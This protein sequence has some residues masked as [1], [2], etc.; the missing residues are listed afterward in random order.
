MPVLPTW[1]ERDYQTVALNQ[2]AALAA[3]GHQRATCVLPCG[4]GKTFVAARN[5]LGARRLL[6][7]TPTVALLTQTLTELAQHRPHDHQLAICAANPDPDSVD[8]THPDNITTTVTTNPDQIATF[9]RQHPGPVTVAC[10]YAS[11]QAAI[12]ATHQTGTVWDAIIL[13]EA[14]RTAGLAGKPWA[15]ILDNTQLPARWR[16]ALTATP[17]QITTNP[18]LTDDNGEPLPVA[19]MTDEALYGPIIEPIS[20]RDAITNGH[21]SDY[22][23]AIVGVPRTQLPTLD[24]RAV[25]PTGEIVNADTIA[26]QIALLR[27]AATH[28]HI[29]SVLAFHN[30]VTAS[31]TWAADWQAIADTPT[32]TSPPT[33][34]CTHIDGT[35]P[36]PDRATALN[37]LRNVPDNT[38]RVVTNCKVLSEGIDVPALDA[39]VFAQPRTSAPDIVQIVGRCLRPHPTRA[40]KATIVIPILIDDT[41]RSIETA[42]AHSS[43]TAVW[44]VLTALA[45]ED[46]ALYNTLAHQRATTTDPNTPPPDITVDIEFDLPEPLP[47]TLTE[48][49]RLRVLNRTTSG[50]AVYAA[51]MRTHTLQGH[52]TH[53]RHTYTT[54][55]GYPLGRRTHELRRLHHTGKLH[56]AITHHIE[57]TIPGW[58][59]DTRP[60]TPRRTWDDMATI[61]RRYLTTTGA[62]TIPPH[63]ITRDTNG[64]PVKL[65]HWYHH[66]LTHQHHLTPT[67]QALLDG[68]TNPATAGINPG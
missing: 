54:P 23:I 13:D 27:H 10:T 57:T 62:T 20:L 58:T 52:N 60:A 22:R 25:L 6:I 44:Q 67:Q 26:A 34:S 28:P 38:L 66:Q 43:F 2:L 18:T 35:M 5:T 51:K 53:P 68:L 64:Q 36:H 14:H 41:A 55:D 33:T 11:Q 56:P 63:T 15:T 39:V 7:F 29:N 24:G 47:H 4:T 65:G 1:E 40:R 61:A 19:S 12:E 46:T 17:R 45:H 42:A 3:T 50:W 8:D 30:R 31:Q 49:L 16:L 59:W 9:L 21:L 37:S 48:Q 32:L